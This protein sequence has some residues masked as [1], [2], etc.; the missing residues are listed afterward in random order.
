MYWQTTNHKTQKYTNKQKIHNCICIGLAQ[1]T[2]H[3]K[4][5]VTH[6]CAW[7]PPQTHNKTQKHKHT[8]KKNTMTR[9]CSCRRPR[10]QK[11]TT[12]NTKTHKIH[13]CIC[14]GLEKTQN[15]PKKKHTRNST[16]LYMH[17]HGVHLKHI[18][19]HKK[20]KNTHN[21]TQKS[22]DTC[23]LMSLASGINK[24]QKNTKQTQFNIRTQ[25]NNHTHITK[26]TKSKQKNAKSTQKN[27]LTFACPFHR[28]RTNHK[29]QEKTHK[30]HKKTQLYMNGHEHTK[31]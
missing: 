18:T 1:I 8:H 22:N 23:M 28:P 4:K 27:T 6:A 2:K 5:T 30:K 29:M 7:C 21:K 9:A 26:H 11:N 17:A 15:T 19:K 13:N 10:T 12:N 16:H 24:T 31:N 25:S 3:Q 14:I 20:H